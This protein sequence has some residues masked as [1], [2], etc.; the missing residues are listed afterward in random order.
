LIGKFYQCR[1]GVPTFELL[2]TRLARH[3]YF[4]SEAALKPWI[5]G[6][7]PQAIGTIRRPLLTFGT[8]RKLESNVYVLLTAKPRSIF[9]A[10]LQKVVIYGISA[11]GEILSVNATHLAK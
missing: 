1:I 2:M 9:L 8:P 6:D 11:F 5:Y 10:D 4:R 7:S 3:Y